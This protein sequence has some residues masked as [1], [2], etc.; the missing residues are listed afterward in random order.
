[1][2]KVQKWG[3]FLEVGGEDEG[4][5]R[6]AI[7]Q[8]LIALKVIRRLA[9]AGFEYPNR[10][11]AVS[12]FWTLSLSH[13]GNFYSILRREPSN[14]PPEVETL[15]G[16]HILQLSRLHLEMAKVHPAAFVLLPQCIELAHSYWGLVAEL[17]KSYSSPDLL[18]LQI[19][20]DGDADEDEKSLLE[21]IGLRA[22]LLLRA[23]AKL[24]FY[25]VNS[26]KYP[27]PQ[28]KEEKN[29]SVKLLKSQ[30]F[31][32]DFVIQVMELLVT[33]YFV[34][35][36]SDLREWEE[37]PEEWEKR[38]EEITDA[39]EFSIRSCSEKLFLDLVINFKD[40]LVPKL[41]HVFYTYASKFFSHVESC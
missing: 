11:T 4:G 39:W 3:S 32:E 26:F 12:E 22:L 33:Q 2:D 21:K 18:N 38:E 5:A 15:I 37:E 1:M 17:G 9:V 35:R 24:A 14:L 20:T 25:P 36:Q 13:F 6:E 27:T 10:E 8:S 28:F 41:L 23:C 30:L 29:Q 19:G 16:K 31:T 40:L 34:F 7:E